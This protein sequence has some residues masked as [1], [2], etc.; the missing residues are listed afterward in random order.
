VARSPSIC[1]AALLVL[2]VNAFSAA[3]AAYTRVVGP[4]SKEPVRWKDPAIELFVSQP[5]LP[6]ELELREVVAALTRATQVWSTGAVCGGLRFVVRVTDE[7]RAVA[8]GMSVVTFRRRA[9]CKDGVERPGNCYDA[10]R[11]AVTTLHFEGDARAERI[12]D[13]DVELNAVDFR[14][15]HEPGPGRP[16]A[17]LSPVLAHELG[18]VLGFGHPCAAPG[19]RPSGFVDTGGHAFAPCKLTHGDGAMAT[20]MAPFAERDAERI[21]LSPDDVRGVCDVYGRSRNGTTLAHR[22]SDCGCTLAERG[23]QA[24]PWFLFVACTLLARRALKHFGG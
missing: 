10:R 8:D 13:A 16:L 24:A 9:W 6:P 1:C 23:E 12:A 18:H 22:T 20:L 5:T 21:V 3:S 19:E 4:N 15:G 17:Q 14:W 2:A 7:D 11:A